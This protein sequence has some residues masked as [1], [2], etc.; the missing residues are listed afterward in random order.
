MFNFFKPNSKKIKFYYP[1][2]RP[3][4]R[5]EKLLLE[6]ILPDIESVGFKYLKSE[7]CFKRNSGEFINEISFQKNKWN[8]GN[9]VCAFK[10]ILTIYSTQLPKYLKTTKENKQ[11]Y[12]V[13]S[14]V[15]Y[16]EGWASE[17]FN[18]YYDLAKHD[19]FEIISILRSNIQNVAI[20]YFEA[21]KTYRDVVEYYI[22]NEK[23]YYMAP[24]IFDLCKM[25]DDKVY[26]ERILDWFLNFKNLGEKEF[27]Q[28][29]LN[30][31]ESCRLKLLEWK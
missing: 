9:D 26:A 7:M 16:V 20:P 4:E 27:H 8:G 23:R 15:E 11:S 12:F 6:F 5:I 1:E 22:Q 28:D 24:S 14:S 3:R 29:T 10:P 25:H 2:V 18:G 30:K 19:N 13:G 21:F 31:I 17:Y